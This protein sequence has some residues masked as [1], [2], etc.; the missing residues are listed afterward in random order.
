VKQNDLGE[1]EENARE[2]Q[3]DTNMQGK[4]QG[5]PQTK[6][7]GLQTPSSPRKEAKREESRGLV[8]MSANCLS[9]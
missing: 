5:P 4:S 9:V 8:K 3:T 6:P 7:L 1:S 2:K